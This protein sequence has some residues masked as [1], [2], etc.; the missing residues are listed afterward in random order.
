MP[1]KDLY[2][3]ALIECGTETLENR[4]EKMCIKLI[5]DMKDP[6]HKLNELLP[7]TYSWS[8]TRERHE[9]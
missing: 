9:T 5:S 2:E 4:R 6:I 1:W 8:C 3:Q 7:C